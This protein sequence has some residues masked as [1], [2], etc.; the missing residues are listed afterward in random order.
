MTPNA[1]EILLHCHVCSLPHPR[2]DA[3]AVWNELQSF[4]A[5]GLIEEEPGS[6]GGY[7]TTLR[8][9]LHV[10]Q[11]CNTAWPVSVFMGADGKVM[12]LDA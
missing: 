7:G 1:I 3:P 5:N 6:P 4:L 9:R 12:E 11:L 8:G 10:Q 2:R